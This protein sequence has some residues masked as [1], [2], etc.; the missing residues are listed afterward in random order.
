[1]LLG[2]ERAHVLQ[3]EAFLEGRLHLEAARPESAPSRCPGSDAAVFE[4]KC[5][6]NKPPGYPVLVLPAVWLAHQ[7]FDADG[8]YRQILVLTRLLNALATAGA[9]TLLA[10]AAAAAAKE[11]ADG[12]DTSSHR[13]AVVAGLG[14]GL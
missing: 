9:A 6:S 8:R 2:N 1:I 14:F 5:Y 11:W 10:A 13:A 4:G 3:A 7:V 12:P